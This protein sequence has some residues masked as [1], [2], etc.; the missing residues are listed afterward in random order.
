MNY[1]QKYAFHSDLKLDKIIIFRSFQ[2]TE[3]EI[4]SLDHFPQ[5]QVPY[6]DNVT[7]NQLKDAATKVLNRE[8]SRHCLIYFPLNLNLLRI[9]WSN[10]SM[11]YLNQGLEK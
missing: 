6:F 9:L 8:R 1:C 7:F 4:Y 5:S 3:E 11:T 2:Q 10:G